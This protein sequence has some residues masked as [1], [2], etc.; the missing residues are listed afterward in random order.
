MQIFHIGRCYG[1][2]EKDTFQYECCE[3]NNILQTFMLVHSFPFSFLLKYK[4]KT[5]LRPPSACRHE[6]LLQTLNKTFSDK[7]KS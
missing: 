5:I 4:S 1:L 7:K 3:N 2:T 6:I